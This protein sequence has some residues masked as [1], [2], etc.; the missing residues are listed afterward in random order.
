MQ[1]LR[2]LQQSRPLTRFLVSVVL[3]TTLTGVVCAAPETQRPAQL[4]GLDVVEKIGKPVDLNL[5][6]QSET[7][8]VVKLK[9]LIK[10]DRPTILALA[11]YECP[12]LCTLVLNGLVQSLDK[13][14]WTA[15]E[16]F[17]VVTISVDPRET[18]QMAGVKRQAYLAAYGRD[19][20]GNWPFLTD[21]QDNVK[22][23]ATQVGWTY[24]YDERTKQYAH[25]AALVVLTPDGRVARY[26]YGVKF[27]P[28][29]VRLALTEAGEGKVGGF[30]EKVLMFC[31]QYDP[32]SQSYVMFAR[33]FM[34][35]GGA[36]VMLI[37][38]GILVHFWRRERSRGHHKEGGHPAPHIA[39]S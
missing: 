30:T 22:K 16:Q 14:E 7:G 31:Y 37:L 17:N 28:L 6:F 27:R 35:A 23:L 4:Q 19:V 15:G 3:A 11:Y 13:V 18:P 38:G 8:R 24:R 5:E 12:M 20:K 2:R 29:D 32:S 39:A 36:L 34:S 9:S 10:P 26:L 33:R 21:Y 25:P 1:R